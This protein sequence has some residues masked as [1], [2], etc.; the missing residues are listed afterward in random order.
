VPNSPLSLYRRSVL[1]R[2]RHLTV[3]FACVALA[4]LESTAQIAITTPG[5]AVTENFD[6]LGTSATATLPAHWRMTAAG[7]STVTWADATNVTAT[8][9][10]A[11][12]NSPTTGGR[13]NWGQS[14][15][16][17]AIGFMTSSGYASPNS[18][19]AS[20]TN[21]TGSTIHELTIS[22]DY[23]R[24]RLNT[25]AAS[26][27]FSY[28]TDGSNWIS[29]SAGDS[30]AFSTGSSSYGFTTLISSQSRSVTLSSLDLNP[31]SAFYLR[32]HFNTTG[33]NSQGLG[34]DNFS[35]TASAVPEPSTYAAI[36]G[37]T[38]LLGAAWHRRRPRR[39]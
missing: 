20:F 21:S 12:A 7:T 37:A 25:A 31:D 19:L 23:E 32:W 34:L 36:A 5:V 26:I 8:T 16:D 13:Y 27:S 39:P 3:A 33:A 24:Y 38:A 6:S 15:T 29:A 9:Q 22:F 17:R 14:S 18:I 30:G 4:N 35:L 2:P 11:S 10:Q 28:S 1:P